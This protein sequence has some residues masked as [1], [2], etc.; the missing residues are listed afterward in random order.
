MALDWNFD[1]LPE[2]GI[3]HFLM[4]LVWSDIPNNHLK[5]PVC[6]RPSSSGEGFMGDVNI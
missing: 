6:G 1:W 2:F 5:N 3:C 4:P